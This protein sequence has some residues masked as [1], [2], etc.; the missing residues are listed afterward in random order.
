MFHILKAILACS[1]SIRIIGARVHNRTLVHGFEPLSTD[2][3]CTLCFFPVKFKSFFDAHDS[4]LSIWGSTNNAN[5]KYQTCIQLHL[6]LGCLSIRDIRCYILNKSRQARLA[7]DEHAKTKWAIPS[8][9]HWTER[10]HTV[11]ITV[12]EKAR[13][14][15][16]S[17]LLAVANVSWRSVMVSRASA[18]YGRSSPL[19][20]Q[21]VLP[22]LREWCEQSVS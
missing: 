6:G 16:E 17:Q 15:E 1:V 11:Q 7:R 2:W 18:S 14:A 13:R 22:C 21:S 3:E 4:A 12:E 8:F 9:V 10:L 20:A 5:M 19:P